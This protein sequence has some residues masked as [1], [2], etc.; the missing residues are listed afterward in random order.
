MPATAVS[1]GGV[2]GST[3]TKV[4]S[5]CT[6]TTYCYTGIY[7]IENNKTIS[8]FPNPLTTSATIKIDAPQTF[9]NTTA[10]LYDML[11]NKV[12]EVKLQNNQATLQ[13]GN[14]PSGIYFYKVIS[15]NTVIGQGKV[16]VE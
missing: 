6:V 16:A 3:S 4:L 13:R 1:S 11:G 5:G 2:A 8:I 14:L 7:E 10:Q 9:A 15:E 12:S